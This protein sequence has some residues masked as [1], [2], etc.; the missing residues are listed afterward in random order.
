MKKHILLVLIAILI[1][2]S[3]W[4]QNIA[5]NETKIIV[6]VKKTT[7]TIDKL[8]HYPTFKDLST[9]QI[10]KTYPGHIFYL[11]LLKGNYTMENDEIILSKNATVTIYTNKQYYPKSDKLSPNHLKTS[12][13]LKI[14]KTKAVVHARKEGEIILKTA[15]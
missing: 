4:A 10:E 1:S 2:Q 7:N 5:T 8:V 3:S 11:G 13:S 9:A 6:V 15:Q 14:G 12:E